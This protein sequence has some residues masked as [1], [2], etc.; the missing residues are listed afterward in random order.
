MWRKTMLPGILTQN[1]S[2]VRNLIWI[3]DK[4]GKSNNI[5]MLQKTAPWYFFYVMY[6]YVLI[7]VLSRVALFSTT[8]LRCVPWRHLPVIWG[9]KVKASFMGGRHEIRA[10]LISTRHWIRILF[11]GYQHYPT[12][13]PSQ[14]EYW[15]VLSFCHEVNEKFTVTT[16]WHNDGVT[17]T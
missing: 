16:W 3:K 4:S 15:R 6:V 1:G 9:I 13:A 11:S 7:F 17:V 10:E 8:W 14:R 5:K 2:W 12:M